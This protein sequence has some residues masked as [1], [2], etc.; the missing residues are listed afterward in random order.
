MDTMLERTIKATR[1]IA[2]D[3][4]PLML[5]DLGLVPA[6]QWLVE[7]FRERHGIECDITITPP[8]I[9]LVDPQATA[10]YR[11]MQES[12]QNA[13]RHAKASRVDVELVCVDGHVHLRVRD[14]GLGFDLANPRTPNSVGL[15]GLRERAHLV[16]G[17]IIID[18]APGQ[19]T[20]IDV[21][22]PLP[23]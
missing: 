2:A 18:T 3:L 13:A 7:S 21:R 17:E 15:V 6:A 22:I 19:G 10:V 14:D 11:I 23:G 9:E 16:D 4:R 20:R 12:L 1:R 5:D 8:D